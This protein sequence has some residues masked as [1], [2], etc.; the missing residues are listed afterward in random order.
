MKQKSGVHRNSQAEKIGD[1]FS[2]WK[3][4]LYLQWHTTNARN[5]NASN[6]KNGRPPPGPVPWP[7][8]KS[9]SSK[10]EYMF[11]YIFKYISPPLV[12]IHHLGS[13]MPEEGC[14]DYGKPAGQ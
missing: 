1:R 3:N 2:K 14:C 6:Q 11:K 4:I 8:P 13:H 12:D 7:R 9:I 10:S 5:K